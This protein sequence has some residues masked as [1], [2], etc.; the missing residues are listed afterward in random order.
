MVKNDDTKQAVKQKMHIEAF[1]PIPIGFGQIDEA[2]NKKNLEFIKIKQLKFKKNPGGG[3]NSA[4]KSTYILDNDEL[5]DIKKVLTDS[6][7]EY[8]KEIMKP[9]Q[10]IKLYITNSWINV[11]KNGE[12]HHIHH[13]QNSIV[14]AVLYIDICEEDTITFVNPY[15]T[16]FGNLRFGNSSTMWNTP[17]WIIPIKM[18]TLLMFP[19]SLPHQ[20]NVR[21]NTC[22]GTRISLSFNTWFKGTIGSGEGSSTQLHL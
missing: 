17:D 20:V 11:N 12:S 4:T 14:S 21:P 16:L 18:N 2:L 22:T 15:T 19:S 8:F 3:G 6:V 1:F 13:H 9:A 7:N 10:D 5:S